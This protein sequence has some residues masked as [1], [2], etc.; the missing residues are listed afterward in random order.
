MKLRYTILG[1][2]L[3][4]THLSY[5][6]QLSKA[7]YTAYISKYKDIA[8]NEM[9]VNKIPASITLAQGMIESGCG[10]SKLAVESNNHFGIK[11]KADWTGDTYYYNDDRPHECFRK[12]TTVD[13]SYHDHS[14]FLTSRARYASL[15]TLP[16]TDYKGWATGLK[17]A[18]YA[19]N[20]EYANILIKAIETYELYKLDDIPFAYEPIETEI[21]IPKDEEICIEKE[22]VAHLTKRQARNAR[23]FFRK[24][25]V[26][27][28][29]AKYQCIHTSRFG[30]KVYRNYRVPF[31]FARNGDTWYSIAKEFQIF[32]CQV[33]KL[34]DYEEK[35]TIVKGQILYL[36][37]KNRK[38]TER[39]YK[40]KNGD[41][42]YSISQDKCVKL[43]RILKYNNLRL[44][45]EIR[46]GCIVKL[47]KIRG[48]IK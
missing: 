15:F 22:N 44:G 5:S 12:Y 43:T 2:A 47:K 38:N 17:Q 3:L 6:Q 32:S 19:T 24:N 20:P 33:Y 23:V 9:Q 34:N 42:I 46:P 4:V 18:G 1:L 31:I 16:I 36:E 45:E 30:R 14:L 28:D 35:D 7:D 8:I 21:I 48:K 26:M 29:S 40:V 11:C 27:P 25:Y 41:S 39:I 10:K 13:E 37:P